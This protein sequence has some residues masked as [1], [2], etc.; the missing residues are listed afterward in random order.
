KNSPKMT[1]IAGETGPVKEAMSKFESE[2]FQCVQLATSHAFH[3]K[4][5]APANEPLRRFLE[6]LEIRWPTI[7]ITS[8]VDGGWYPMDDGGDSK[9]A[10]LS[11]LAPQMASSVEWTKQIN[12]MYEAGARIFLEVGPKR[13]LTVFAT[14]I[15][16]DM[17]SISIMTNHPKTGGISSLLNAIGTMALAGRIPAKLGSDS[18]HLTEA[19]RAGPVDS[20][21]GIS[22][23]SLPLKERSRPLPSK[24][25]HVQTHTVTV[26]AETYVDPDTAKKN[27]VGDLISA[28]CGYPSK[29]CQ[30]N[31]DMRAV[32][33][34]SDSQI[35][36]VIQTVH[37]SCKTDP[38]WDVSQ[39]KTVADITRWIVGAPTKS[40]SK[41]ITKTDSRGHDPFVI[42][43]I[44]LGLP[45][46]ERVFDEGNFEKLVRGETCISEVT[47]E[48][49]QIFEN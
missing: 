36:S 27:L 31:V 1:V 5:V 21:D 38:D 37:S 48:Y 42:T 25:G 33:G 43:G 8:N 11:K 6:G 4:I 40:V 23:P 3:S 24:G 34:M 15:L 41:G 10:I 2:G 9:E 13:A 35:Q 32:L 46:G 39:A 12:S 14:Q 47:N 28:H 30:G 7:P 19:F 26:S 45:G 22:K 16:E 17:P 29:F 20:G 49:K 44:S 18:P